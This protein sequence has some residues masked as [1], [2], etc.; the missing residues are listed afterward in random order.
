MSFFDHI[1]GTIAPHICTKCGTEGRLLCDSCVQ[2]ILPVVSRC[3]RCRKLTPR[4]R[5]CPACRKSSKIF[6][7]QVGTTYDATAKQLI[8]KL[9]YDGAQVA[10]I[11]ISSFIF[12][13]TTFTKD[14]V[15]VPVP[16]AT[17]RVRRRGYDQAKLIARSLAK[18]HQLPY[19]D[20][21]MRSGQTH[22][23]GANRQRRLKQLADA[24]RI[25]G[26][27]DVTSMHIVLVD[28]VSTTGATLEAAAQC[29]K[30]AGAK[31]VEAVV[32]AQA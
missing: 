29:L 15:F 26:L 27:Y 28:D 8:A 1:I 25:N 12:R 22:Q 18:K 31:R 20:C 24:Y 4:F 17:T 14:C 16:T 7:L 11:E 30:S 5:T 13:L 19:F 6:R 9:K 10:A 32:F 21:L 23:I 3:Y 2:T